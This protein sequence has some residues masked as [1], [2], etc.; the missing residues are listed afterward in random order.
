[1]QATMENVEL[2]AKLQSVLPTLSKM[3]QHTGVLGGAPHSELAGTR[4]TSLQ[5]IF[6]DFCCEFHQ[7]FYHQTSLACLTGSLQA[8]HYWNSGGEALAALS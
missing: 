4:L 3:V 1:M 7:S 2:M 8:L 5:K 6:Q